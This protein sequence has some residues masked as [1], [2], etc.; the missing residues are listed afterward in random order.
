MGW[1]S[2]GGAVSMTV[3]K[4]SPVCSPT[5]DASR[6]RRSRS[7]SR[8]GR[9]WRAK[10]RFAAAPPGAAGEFS[11]ASSSAGE[12]R[13]LLLAQ[14][15]AAELHQQRGRRDAQ[16]ADARRRGQRAVG[17]CRRRR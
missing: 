2:Q 3:A 7:R 9:S 16:R 6:S 14:L 4:S 8:R 12:P 1:W 10:G 13:H 5:S 11:P 15:G 17:R